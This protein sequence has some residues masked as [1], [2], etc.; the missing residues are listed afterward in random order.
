M[1]EFRSKSTTSPIGLFAL[2]VTG[3]G[4]ELMVCED[5]FNEGLN[6]QTWPLR[7]VCVPMMMGWFDPFRIVNSGLANVRLMLLYVP[8]GAFTAFSSA[9]SVSSCVSSTSMGLLTK[10][11]G[12]FDAPAG[13]K[14]APVTAISKDKTETPAGGLSRMDRLTDRGPS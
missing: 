3:N 4:A 9:F 11:T 13:C 1:E 8:S 14:L 6:S 5:W 10:E 12:D 7:Q 2:I